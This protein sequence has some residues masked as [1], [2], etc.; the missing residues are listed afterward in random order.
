MLIPFA[1]SA[2]NFNALPVQRELDQV[3]QAAIQYLNPI[4]SGMVDDVD[5]AFQKAQSEIYKAGFAKVLEEARKQTGEYLS[6]HKPS[7]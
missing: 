1:Y 2:F 7:G 5:K 6:L 3:N 4:L